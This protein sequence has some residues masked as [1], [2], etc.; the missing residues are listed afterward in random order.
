[1][2]MPSMRENERIRNSRYASSRHTPM[3]APLRAALKLRRRHR[4]A[5]AERCHAAERDNTVNGK[6]HEKVINI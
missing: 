5:A 1:M 2:F 3:S 6:H 4:A